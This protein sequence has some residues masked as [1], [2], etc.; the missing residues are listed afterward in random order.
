MFERVINCCCVDPAVVLLPSIEKSTS[1][2][3]QTRE[4][5]DQTKTWN[6]IAAEEQPVPVSVG[7]ASRVL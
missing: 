6:W 4:E 7:F 3:K 2:L 1:F 5:E